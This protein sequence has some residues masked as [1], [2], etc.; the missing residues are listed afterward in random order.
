MVRHEG[1]DHENIIKN[2]IHTNVL[3]IPLLIVVFTTPKEFHYN[4]IFMIF[5]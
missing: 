2:I 4:N 3:F 1:F 5:L